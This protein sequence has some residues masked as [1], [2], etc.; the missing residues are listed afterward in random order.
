M[1]NSLSVREISAGN[2]SPSAKPAQ[3]NNTLGEGAEW[4]A[5]FTNA[6][7]LCCKGPS[8]CRARPVSAAY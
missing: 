6:R 1:A 8:C 7:P 4:S 3:L 5:G 2:T